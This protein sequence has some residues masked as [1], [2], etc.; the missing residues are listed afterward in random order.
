M[1]VEDWMTRD[2]MT[3]ESTDCLGTVRALFERE[4]IRRAPV[5]EHGYL[6][7]IVTER[8]LRG[9]GESADA[10][11]SSVMGLELVTIEPKAPLEEAA[12]LI[13]MHKIGGIPVVQDDRLVGLLTE[14]DIFRGVVQL[15]GFSRPGL[16][17]EVD[18]PPE[19]QISQLA[20]TLE[21]EPA[22]CLSLVTGPDSGPT[23]HRRCAFRLESL[24]PALGERLAPKLRQMGIRI[25]DI[26]R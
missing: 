16:R 20:A 2:V 7:G 9:N 10:L 22:H 1:L 11:V 8:D 19:V 25:L 14:R 18:C 4:G 24:D 5:M 23:H 6:V 3:V 15:T 12:A 17:L 13:V 21:R 26:R